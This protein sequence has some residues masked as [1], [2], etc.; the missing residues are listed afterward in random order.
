MPGEQLVGVRL[1]HALELRGRVSPPFGH[2][3]D[4]N[5]KVYER[6]Q[7]AS[8][9][10]VVPGKGKF[11]HRCAVTQLLAGGRRRSQFPQ[12]KTCSPNSAGLFSAGS[13][14]GGNR[15]GRWLAAAAGAAAAQDSAHT[16]ESRAQWDR[17][18]RR[19]Q[20]FRR[21]IRHQHDFFLLGLQLDERTKVLTWFAAAIREGWTGEA[22]DRKPCGSTKR[23]GRPHGFSVGR[24]AG[25]VCAAIDGGVAGLSG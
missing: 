18:W 25:T 11:G 14:F 13:A 15:Y 10:A 8:L 3:T 9:F 20:R 4:H 12:T 2:C 16:V 21:E 7:V 5:S 1:D 19:Y 17:S 22:D 6:P 24:K 23:S